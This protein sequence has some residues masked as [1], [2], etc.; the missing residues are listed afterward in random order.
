MGKKILLIVVA[1][2]FLMFHSD[3]LIGQQWVLSPKKQSQTVNNETLNHEDEKDACCAPGHVHDENC[4]HDFVYKGPSVLSPPFIFIPSNR[5]ATQVAPRRGEISNPIPTMPS[6][7]DTIYGAEDVSVIFG[8]GESSAIISG[9]RVDWPYPHGTGHQS[10]GSTTIGQPLLIGSDYSRNIVMHIYEN[11]GAVSGALRDIRMYARTGTSSAGGYLLDNNLAANNPSGELW[12][13]NPVYI[14]FPTTPFVFTVTYIESRDLGDTAIVSALGRSNNPLPLT[15]VP[16]VY[17]DPVTN[18]QAIDNDRFGALF[19]PVRI[20]DSCYVGMYNHVSQDVQF[21]SFNYDEANV[22]YTSTREGKHDDGKPLLITFPNAGNPQSAFQQFVTDSNYVR[23][24][25]VLLSGT[26]TF[27]NVAVGDIEWY[28]AGWQAS[29][30]GYDSIPP[31]YVMNVGSCGHYNGWFAYKRDIYQFTRDYLMPS[32]KYVDGAVRLLDKA[33]ICV[34]GDVVDENTFAKYSL[35]DMDDKITS[36]VLVLPGLDNDKGDRDN[37]RLKIGGHADILHTQDSGYYTLNDPLF[38]NFLYADN[39]TARFYGTGPAFPRTPTNGIWLGS[40][41]NPIP[42][43]EV[44]GLKYDY[45]HP[46]GFILTDSITLPNTEWIPFRTT[47]AS[48]YGVGGDYNG[49][50][51]IHTR[52]IAAVTA[53]TPSD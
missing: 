38:D 1:A 31:F 20:G 24:T 10:V 41:Q 52:S 5:G 12:F 37:F 15:S 8:A 2:S 3:I 34:E 27:D 39:D 14:P 19:Y 46:R 35:G 40:G 33:D 4:N 36:T 6:P 17:T 51:D 42:F 50:N 22:P 28:A 26:S 23:P 45:D 44:T 49:H 53:A 47:Y 30:M 16:E 13:E 21:F 48:V 29:Y 11:N 43:V 7:I 9:T 32:Y 25:T 18:F